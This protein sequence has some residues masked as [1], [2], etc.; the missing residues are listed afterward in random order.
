MKSV[1]LRP[2]FYSLFGLSS[3]KMKTYP[4]NLLYLA[5]YVKQNSDWE[6]EILDGENLILADKPLSVN[7]DPE[8]FMNA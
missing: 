1:L 2:P 8:L 4:L 5:T 7:T 6:I 3:P